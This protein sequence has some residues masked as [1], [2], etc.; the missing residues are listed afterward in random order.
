MKNKPAAPK[1]RIQNHEVRMLEKALASAEYDARK[2]I[3][4]DKRVALD[5]CRRLRAAISKATGEVA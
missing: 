5:E 2:Y 1:T 4:E 3:G